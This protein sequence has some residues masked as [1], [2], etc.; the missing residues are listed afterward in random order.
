MNQ[1]PGLIGKKLGNTQIFEDDGKTDYAKIKDLAKFPELVFLDKYWWIPPALVGFASYAALGFSG[2]F[3][4]FFLSTV[5]LWHGTYTINSLSHVFGWQDYETGEDSKNNFVLALLTL[6]EGWH[7][8][9]HYYMG[10]APQGFRWWQIDITY[11]ILRVLAVFGLVW[12][13][14][15]PPADVLDGTWRP[16][17]RDTP[18]LIPAANDDDD[19]AKA[20]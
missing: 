14:R 4:G 5:L 8:N 11:A 16:G 20:A 10:S 2:L 17:K 6:G 18:L 9:H 1:Y 7:N 12:D 19:T 13:V 3:F 15:T